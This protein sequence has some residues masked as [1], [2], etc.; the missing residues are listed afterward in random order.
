VGGGHHALD[1]AD[2]E[3]T[4]GG[5]LV[6]RGVCPRKEYAERECSSERESTHL[7]RRH[8]RGL[9]VT[10]VDRALKAAVCFPL[11]RHGDCRWGNGSKT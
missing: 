1:P 11:R 9:N 7:T 5:A 8:L 4:Q 10:A 2:F 3:P 6:S